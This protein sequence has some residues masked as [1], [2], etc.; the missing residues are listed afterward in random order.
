MPVGQVMALDE[1]RY[2]RQIA[3]ESLKWSFLPYPEG[4]PRLKQAETELIRNH[5][6]GPGPTTREPIPINSL[7]LPAIRGAGDAMI[8]RDVSVAADRAIEAIRMHAAQNGG[9]L[10]Q[11][12]AEVSVVP[13]PNNP[14]L[15]T[16]FPYKVDGDKATLEVRRAAAPPRPLQES[17]YV[18]EITIATHRKSSETKAA[19]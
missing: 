12:L 11:S 16:P 7:L 6:L 18:F 17:D 8:R 4:W 10:P 5:Y 14:W 1:A 13:V 9:K 19:P 2:S 15:G 3:S